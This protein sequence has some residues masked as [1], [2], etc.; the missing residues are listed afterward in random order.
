MNVELHCIGAAFLGAWRYSE[1]N[2][3]EAFLITNYSTEAQILSYN[4]VFDDPA[5]EGDYFCD[6][7]DEEGQSRLLSVGLYV[8]GRG[9]HSSSFDAQK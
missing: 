2:F 3:S 7:D 4:S 1:G 6:A 9:K 8:N 5:Y